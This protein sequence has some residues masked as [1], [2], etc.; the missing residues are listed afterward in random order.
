[1]TD[2]T[3]ESI[4]RLMNRIHND[5][6][7]LHRVF[8]HFGNLSASY[9]ASCSTGATDCARR[10][11]WAGRSSGR[12]SRG[13]GCCPAEAGVHR[14]AGRSKGARENRVG[15]ACGVGG[16]GRTQL[17]PLSDAYLSLKTAAQP[18]VSAHR[19]NPFSLPPFLRLLATTRLVQLR[20]AASTR[21]LNSG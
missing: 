2:E 17:D 6:T 10:W 21:F 1:L 13:R 9:W 11:R 4:T 14:S 3:S 19:P 18:I 12:W 5:C 15:R 8:T 7:S 20:R 16:R